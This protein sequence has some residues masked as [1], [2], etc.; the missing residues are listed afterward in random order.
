MRSNGGMRGP[1]TL[2]KAHKIRTPVSG[3]EKLRLDRGVGS[4]PASSAGRGAAGANRILEEASGGGRRRRRAGEPGRRCGGGR[5][6]RESGPR[7]RRDGAVNADREGRRGAPCCVACDRWWCYDRSIARGSRSIATPRVTSCLLHQAA[8]LPAAI[9]RRDLAK[10]EQERRGREPPQRTR[11]QEGGSNRLC[12]AAAAQQ[13]FSPRCEEFLVRLSWSSSH[14]APPCAFAPAPSPADPFP[15][16]CSASPSL[17]HPLFD[18]SSPSSAA[19]RGGRVARARARLACAARA[20]GLVA[21][22]GGLPADR[23]SPGARGHPLHPALELR[24]KPL[25][26]P[27]F[28]VARAARLPRPAFSLRVARYGRHRGYWRPA[29]VVACPL[30]RGRGRG[31]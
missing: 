10:R 30:R 1:Q 15:A 27:G 20:L 13:R 31:R 3:R 5:G 4:F 25:S 6:A 26:V 23:A 2:K 28:R 18:S 17:L 16:P 11:A 24:S 19:P 8:R 9:I 12:R 7:R 22:P 14:A 29:G 21:P